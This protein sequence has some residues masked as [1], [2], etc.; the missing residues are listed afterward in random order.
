MYH[1]HRYSPSRALVTSA[2]LLACASVFAQSNAPNPPRPDSPTTVAV[3]EESECE[4][5]AK[6]GSVS[7]EAIGAVSGAVIGGFLGRELGG[8]SAGGIGAFLGG[9]AGSVAGENIAASRTYTCLLKVR[10]AQFGD[11]PVYVLSTKNRPVN[12]GE[13]IKLYRDING[14][15]EAF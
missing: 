13:S 5:V 4:L 12:V 8:R 1:M 7:G 14:A 9:M 15:W 2:L 6:S 3:V 10:N 11:V